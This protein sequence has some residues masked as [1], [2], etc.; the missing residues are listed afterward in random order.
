MYQTTRHVRRLTRAS[1]P[2][3]LC[4]MPTLVT[5]QVQARTAMDL[6]QE[7]DSL[8]SEESGSIVAIQLPVEQDDEGNIELTVKL[9]LPDKTD[10]AD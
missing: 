5:R 4:G 9:S 1:G 8:L 10:T 2:V 7:L 6:A 3:S